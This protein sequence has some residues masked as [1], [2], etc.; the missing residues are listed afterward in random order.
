[1][2][3]TWQFVLGAGVP[4][5]WASGRGVGAVGEP[6]LFPD[7]IFPNTFGRPIFTGVRQ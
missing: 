5:N 4:I 1:M 6:E 2:A 3:D 7:D